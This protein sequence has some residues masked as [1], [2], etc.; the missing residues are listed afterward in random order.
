MCWT[1]EFLPWKEF[2]S[3]DLSPVPLVWC[4]FCITHKG[5]CRQS[6]CRG[7]S[8]VTCLTPLR[9][10]GKKWAIQDN[11]HFLPRFRP[12]GGPQKLSWTSSLL[13]VLI[14]EVSAKRI[15]TFI[16]LVKNFTYALAPFSTLLTSHVHLRTTPDINCE[17]TSVIDNTLR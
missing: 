15:Q 1:N 4:T 2:G 14:N 11:W 13:H 7:V 3:Q 10:V 9:P 12:C 6:C 16:H 8:D 5:R 17:A